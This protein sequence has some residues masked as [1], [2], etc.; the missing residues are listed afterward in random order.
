MEK[1]QQ[2][3]QI[4][5]SGFVSFYRNKFP[6]LFQDSSRTQMD[7]SR[8]HKFT[9]IYSQDLNVNSPYCLPYASYLLA[10]FNK[11]PKLSRTSGLF[12]GFSSPGK[13]QNKIPGF[14]RFSRTRTN[15]GCSGVSQLFRCSGLFQCSRVFRSVPVF[16][17][18]VHAVTV[19]VIA[20]TLI[21]NLFSFNKKAS[22]M[23]LLR[24][25]K[26]N[27]KIQ[28][29]S[30]QAVNCLSHRSNKSIL[31]QLNLYEGSINYTV[32]AN[33][34][35]R[36]IKISLSRENKRFFNCFLSNKRYSKDAGTKLSFLHT[37][38]VKNKE[39]SRE[40]K[41]NTGHCF[42]IENRMQKFRDLKKIH[43]NLAL[44]MV[45]VPYDNR[46]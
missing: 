7:F 30:V 24:G 45:F 19:T 8:A 31:S 34:M 42:L 17:V 27:T 1:Q 13:C 40:S 33:V 26:Y 4:R 37:I 35:L 12:P 3:C 46:I 14:S 39:Q 44:I 41:F 15:P 29:F 18:L 9:F 25:G 20:I 21:I 22:L 5:C 2:H 38:N 11:F 6:G 43:P 23:F 36:F 28:P 16:L 32:S 10:E